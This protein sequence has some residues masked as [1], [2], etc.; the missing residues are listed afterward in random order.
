MRIV[1]FKHVPFEGPAA[2]SN[3]AESRGHELKS[4]EVYRGDSLPST[5]DYDMLLVMGGPMNIYQET[6]Y[7][8]LAAEK[9][10][11]REAI[12]AGK[13]AVG[14][15]LGGQ[16]IADVLGQP[17]T[18]G[19]EVEIGWFPIER[20]EDCPAALPLPE[21]LRV[22]HWHGDTFEIP[23]GATRLFSS[24]GCLN[25]GFLFEERVLGLQCHLE[26]TRESMSALIEA[27]ADEISEGRFTQSAEVMQAEPDGTFARMQSV[28]FALLDQ[29]TRNG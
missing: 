16:L 23:E 1:C 28:L 21:S 8:W 2:F 4:V 10:A 13:F 6:Q 19:A 15:C 18:R 3:W 24:A 29:M 12:Q 25:Q 22:Y 9:S 26:T 17:V 27:C 5:Q 20:A 14:V 11:I 7:P